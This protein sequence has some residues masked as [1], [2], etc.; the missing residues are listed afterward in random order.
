MIEK[1]IRFAFYPALLAGTLG[2]GILAIQQKWDLGLTYSLEVGI[3]LILLIAVERL[4][5]L[6]TDFGM[7]RQSFWRDVRYIAGVAPVISLVRWSAG[8]IA[9]KLAPYHKGPLQNLPLILALPLFLV[10]FEFFQYWFHRFSHEGRTGIGKFLGRVHLAH[11]LPNRVYVVMHAVFHP[12]NALFAALILQLTLIL[13]GVS[14]EVAFL[15]M[16]LI[17]LQSNISHFNADIRAGWLNYVFIGS[18]THR[19]HHA[20]E[21]QRTTNYGNTL[22]LWDIVFG[23]FRYE[24]GKFPDRLGVDAPELYPPSESVL[25]VLAGP[26]SGKTG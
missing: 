2:S 19:L 12:L 9:L 5:P 3:L 20:A 22:A 4:F 15:A 6:R 14:V 26:F 23:T 8:I 11:H 13:S 1:L 7:T 24:P 18:E 16:L 25:K 17:D 10:S 21:S